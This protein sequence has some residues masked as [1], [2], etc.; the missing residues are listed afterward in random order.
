LENEINDAYSKY[1]L[2]LSLSARGSNIPKSDFSA[3]YLPKN[4][5]IHLEYSTSSSPPGIDGSFIVGKVIT[6][7]VPESGDSSFVL[8]SKVISPAYFLMMA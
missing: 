4:L 7:V 2:W 1:V 6:K 3:N 5:I 8:V